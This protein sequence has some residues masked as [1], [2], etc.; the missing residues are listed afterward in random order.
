MV[1]FI[2]VSNED[3]DDG[4]DNYLNDNSSNSGN[5]GKNENAIDVTGCIHND[6]MVN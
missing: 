1:L 4:D 6:M 2:D 5:S 3:R